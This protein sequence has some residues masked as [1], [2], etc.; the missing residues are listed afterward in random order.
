MGW[1]PNP[2]RYGRN[3][4]KNTLV[5]LSTSRQKASAGHTTTNE[6][7]TDNAKGERVRAGWG[8]DGRV[9]RTEGGYAR[10]MPICKTFPPYI[11]LYSCTA[12]NSPVCFRSSQSCSSSRLRSPQCGVSD[13][14]H[15]LK[16]ICAFCAHSAASAY[17]FPVSTQGAG[18]GGKGRERKV[19]NGGDRDGVDVTGELWIPKPDEPQNSPRYV[20]CLLCSSPKIASHLFFFG[21]HTASTR[22]IACL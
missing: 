17:R 13:C 11:S 22:S 21:P 2:M 12:C 3:G 1:T 4:E 14:M 18:E 7:C 9:G 16:Q 5:K 8:G 20:S 15:S 6:V 10:V 19:G